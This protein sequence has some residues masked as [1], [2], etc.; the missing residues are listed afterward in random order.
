M[1]FIGQ[2]TDE[3]APEDSFGNLFEPVGNFDTVEGRFSDEQLMSDP[4][5]LAGNASGGKNS[6]INNRRNRRRIAGLEIT[7]KKEKVEN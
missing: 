5:Y 1:A 3:K 7:E 6:I 4:D 2:T